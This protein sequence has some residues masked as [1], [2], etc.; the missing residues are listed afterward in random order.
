M[1]LL[2]AC[3]VFPPTLVWATPESDPLAE[4]PAEAGP[5]DSSISVMAEQRELYQQAISALKKGERRTYRNLAQQLE[6]YPLHP[7]LEYADL[8]GRLWASR[9]KEVDAFLKKHQ[10]T[11]V[12]RQLRHRWLEYLR[13]RNHWRDFLR[14]HE[15]E[16]GTVEQRCYYQMARHHNGQREEAIAEALK[17]WDVGKSQPAA[18]DRLFGILI[19]GNLITEE[20]AWSRFTKAMLNRQYR[21]ARYL[22][23][24]FTSQE[25]KRM[26]NDFYNIG[27]NPRQL[28]RIKINVELSPELLGII[29]HSIVHRARG[30]ALSALGHWN[31]FSQMYQFSPAAEKKVITALVKRLFQQQEHAVADNYLKDNRQ[32]V[33]ASLFEWRI[34]Q[35]I[36]E[37]AWQETLDWIAE[38]P[39]EYQLEKRWRYW[40]TRA[41]ELINP[42]D[43]SIQASYAELAGERNFYSFLAGEKAGTGYSMGHTPSAPLPEE[44]EHLANQPAFL[45]IRELLY[46]N[47]LLFARR[48]WSQA[49]RG[50]DENQWVTAAHVAQQIGWPHRAITSMIEA[51]YWDD[52]DIRFPLAYQ[53]IF[54]SRAKATAVPVA[55]LFALARQESSMAPDVSSPAG[56]RGLMQLLP[57][58]AKATA[59]KHGVPFNGTPDLYQP[60][61]NIKLGS[62]YFRDMLDRFDNNRILAAAAYNAGPTRVSRW[63]KQTDGSLPFDAWIEQIPFKE[64]RGYVQSVMAFSAI[65]SHRLGI[66]ETMLNDAEKNNL[67]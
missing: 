5:A 21:L 57:A 16:S 42:D 6:N 2:F 39:A 48:E 34:R 60:E 20:T 67:L 44:I 4:S 63:R 26:A 11:P 56:A 1:P 3:V 45:R 41:R 23:R 65:Y 52:I 37:G 50:F 47:E 24:F 7:Y 19:N 12:A 33:D 28:D 35:A 46:H 10:G 27:R 62:H 29:E 14:Y 51:S 17:L 36:A 59:R 31:R 54:T 53:D 66:A 55:W 49:T 64:T 30:S 15:A 38:L 8:T 32:K 61:L 22:K 43:T 25:Y 58:T 9:H 40:H 18:C 13:K